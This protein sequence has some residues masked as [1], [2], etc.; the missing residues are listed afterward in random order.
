MAKRLVDEICWEAQRDLAKWRFEALKSRYIIINRESLLEEHAI[1]FS[2]LDTLEARIHIDDAT[3]AKAKPHLDFTAGIVNVKIVNEADSDPMSDLE[4]D[5]NALSIEVPVDEPHLLPPPPP[6]ASVAK[7]P[8]IEPITPLATPLVTPNQSPRSIQKD[9]K[10]PTSSL[11]YRDIVFIPKNAPLTDSLK[12]KQFAEM[13]A[14]TVKAEEDAKLLAC[15]K[16]LSDGEGK[17]NIELGGGGGDEQQ[18][19][20]QQQPS[21]EPKPWGWISEKRTKNNIVIRRFRFP[22]RKVPLTDQKE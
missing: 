22:E 1:S 18:L 3:V 9:L 2:P 19:R 17:E 7:T 14:K 10:P 12:K 6:P 13:L 5:L 8:K 15:N 11:P 20:Q 21:S 4:H 16:V